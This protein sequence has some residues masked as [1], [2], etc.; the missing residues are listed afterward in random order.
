MSSSLILAAVV[1]ALAGAALTAIALGGWVRSVTRRN[2]RLNDDL[3]RS[4]AEAARS[5]ERLRELEA[6]KGSDEERLRGLFAKVS[7]EALTVNA[8]QFLQLAET[9]LGAARDAAAVEL[10]R[11]TDAVQQILEPLG[12]QLERYST[13]VG[14]MEN[15][16]T[17]AYR[18]LLERVDA[19]STLGQN[20]QHETARLVQS[21][22][23]PQTRGRWGELQLRRVVELAGMV[24]KVDFIEQVSADGETGKLRPDMVIN[25]PGG[26]TI[27][28]DSKVPLQAFLDANDATTEAER[29]TALAR[30]ASQ[31]RTHITQLGSKEYWKQFPTAPDYVVCFIPGEPLANAAFEQDPSL[32]ED[33]LKLNVIPATPTNLV[34]LLKTVAHNWRYEDIEQK[35]R[36]VI[37]LGAE[38]YDRLRTV[39]GHLDQMRKSLTKTVDS[40][41]ALLGSVESRLLVTARTL[42]DANLA[43]TAAAPIASPSEIEVVARRVQAPALT[44][45]LEDS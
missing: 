21:L 20:L 23:A 33:A 18:L 28:V 17:D 38:L 8:E 34:T 16:R 10:D 13:A 25:L 26:G 5:S 41:N 31:L 45:P 32:M 7:Q 2:A 12:A 19:L 9:R 27:V 14:E 39:S 24:N 44:T 11:R 4:T 3:L 42:H 1:G 30:H 40:Y 6:G 29:A 37:D 43:G 36:A 22:R 15:R 35:A